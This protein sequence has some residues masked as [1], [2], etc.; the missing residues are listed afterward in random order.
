MLDIAKNEMGI[1]LVKLDV[2][3]EN[4]RARRLYEKCGFKYAGRID[5]AINHYGR[6]MASLIMVKE[7]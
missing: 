2:F 4:K 5:K 6:L 1:K 7:L 3:E